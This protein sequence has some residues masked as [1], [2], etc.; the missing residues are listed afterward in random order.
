L[1]KDIIEEFLLFCIKSPVRQEIY[2]V[3]NANFHIKQKNNKTKQNKEEKMGKNNNGDGKGNDNN[4]KEYN[5][6]CKRIE[7]EIDIIDLYRKIEEKERS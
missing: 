3:C 4:Q 1:L 5:N 2:K 7:K 6:Y